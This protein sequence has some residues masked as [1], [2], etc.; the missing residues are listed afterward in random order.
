MPRWAGTFMLLAGMIAWL[1]M[2]AVSLWLKQ[3]P[4][5]ILIG[6]PAGLWLA[7]SRT[8]TITRRGEQND[9]APT[10]VEPA[11]DQEGDPA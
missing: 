4:S 8:S 6:F 11:A 2:V 5:A 1:S 7:L 3:I 10:D 9:Q